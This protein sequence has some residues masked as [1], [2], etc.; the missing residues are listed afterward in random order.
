MNKMSLQE[1]QWLLS[2][3]KKNGFGGSYFIPDTLIPNDYLPRHVQVADQVSNYVAN[4][5]RYVLMGVILRRMV[6][7]CTESIRI[8]I[9]CVIFC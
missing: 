8:E 9:S 3:L 5:R 7:V 6:G 1:G 4:L 2:D